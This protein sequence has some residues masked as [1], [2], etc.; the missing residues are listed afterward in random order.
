MRSIAVAFLYL[1]FVSHGVQA[2]QKRALLIGIGNYPAGSGWKGLSSLNDIDYL[3][4]ILPLKGFEPRYISTLTDEQA[5]KAGI[6]RAMANLVAAARTG[7]RVGPH[8]SSALS[9]RTRRST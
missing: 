9:R 5:T 2:Q 4:S 3:K 1:L 8:R 7:D 6:S